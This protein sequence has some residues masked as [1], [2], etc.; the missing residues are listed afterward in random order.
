MNLIKDGEY[1]ILALIA[2]LILSVILSAVIFALIM[3]PNI[4]IN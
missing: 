4:K 2:I 3:F 1:I